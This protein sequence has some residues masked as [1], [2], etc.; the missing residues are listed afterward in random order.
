MRVLVGREERSGEVRSVVAF[1]GPATERLTVAQTTRE[2]DGR[3]H[4][5]ETWARLNACFKRFCEEKKID[6]RRICLVAF[7]SLA[8]ETLSEKSDLDVLVVFDGN[9]K[10]ETARQ[11]VEALKKEFWPRLDAF[12]WQAFSCAGFTSLTEID[13]ATS[14]DVRAVAEFRSRGMTTF[15]GFFVPD[16][17]GAVVMEE[18]HSQLQQLRVARSA[19][20]CPAFISGDEKTFEKV[21]ACTKPLHTREAF[22]EFVEFIHPSELVEVI[23][24]KKELR[25]WVDAYNLLVLRHGLSGHPRQVFE[26]ALAKKIIAENEFHVLMHAAFQQNEFEARGVK[27]D[28]IV[29]KTDLK[30]QLLAQIIEVRE[31]VNA[32]IE[33]ETRDIEE[34]GVAEI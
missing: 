13:L 9:E 19:L 17:G 30:Q 15:S 14:F 27:Y 16:S 24:I 8:R 23:Q 1:R 6:A 4:S 34:Y 20:P 5:A 21:V 31:V 3:E 7:G 12:F 32:L 33:R 18:F 29:R 25:R 22:R 11:V 10:R 28:E 2:K 26:E